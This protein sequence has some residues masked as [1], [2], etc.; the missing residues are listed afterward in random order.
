MYLKTSEQEKLELG[1]GK[2][3]CNWGVH[4]AG[5]YETEEERDLIINGFFAK[6]I[7]SGDM[8][9]YCPSEQTEEE[10]HHK[11][12][13]YCPEC[14]GKIDDP[15]YFFIQSAKELYYPNGTF[16]PVAMDKGLNEFYHQ[17]QKNGKRNIRGI[18]EMVWALG[19]VPGVEHL[20]AY[21]ARLNYFIPN[22]PWISLCMYNTSKFTGSMIIQVLKTHPYILNGNVLMQNPHF[23]DP[24]KWLAENAP[25][26]LPE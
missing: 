20:M 16:S 15:N 6:G 14:S 12:E 25:Q 19:A 4:I 11:F 22:K 23:E 17:S 1:V 21:E 3:S 10:F 13:D 8:Q 7:Q 2:Y 9:L 5:L 26:F 24:A 18:G